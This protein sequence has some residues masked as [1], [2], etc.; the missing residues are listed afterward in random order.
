MGFPGSRDKNQSVRWHDPEDHLVE[1]G[2]RKE[3]FRGEV[4]EVSPAKPGH[5]DTH[6]RLAAAVELCTGPAYISSVDLL[7]RRSID[8]DFATDAC[9]R[10]RG[11]DPETGNRHLEELTFEVFNTQSRATATSRARDLIATGVRR[12]IG[13][14]VEAASAKDEE[15]G[16]V[17]VTVEEWSPVEEQWLVR[18]REESIEDPCLASPLPIVSLMDATGFDSAAVGI[19]LDKGNPALEEF[20]EARFRD[21]KD[22]GLAA[23]RTATLRAMASRLLAQRF[24]ELPGWVDDRIAAASD[25]ELEGW[26][27][28]VLTASSL[29]Q[30]FVARRS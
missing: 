15:A 14:F 27:D 2:T 25:D 6:L 13:L 26:L 9:V 23:G 11:L 10:K 22:E 30:V 3:M 8:S 19:L 28:R 1:P 21:G 20:G 16:D 17:S 5:G 29:D 24:D 4:I 7:T 18:G 12:V